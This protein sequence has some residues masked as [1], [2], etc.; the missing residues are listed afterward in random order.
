[1]SII[2][3]LLISCLISL[4]F[5]EIKDPSDYSK[6]CSAFTFSYEIES[7]AG[8]RQTLTIN[9]KGGTEPYQILVFDELGEFLSFDFNQTK[10]TGVAKGKYTCVVYD[11]MK[12][13]KKS[14]I[15][16]K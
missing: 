7:E 1:M 12:C 5:F 8:D 9:P 4:N 10:F 14:E 13:L 3:S 16:I 2:N 6:E 11:K 15:E